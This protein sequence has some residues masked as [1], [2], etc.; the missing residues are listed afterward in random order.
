MTT[1]NA[2]VEFDREGDPESVR[3]HPMN[4]R[5]HPDAQKAAMN[6]SLDRVGWIG[7]VTAN[8]RTGH[9]LDGHER[10]EEAL[11]RGES[12]PII[13]VDIPEED[14]PFVLATFD[15]IAA[16][17]EYDGAVLAE[18]AELAD[19]ETPDLSAFLNDYI[20]LFVGPPDVNDYNDDDYDPT[21]T[22]GDS[23]S[24]PEVSWLRLEV[25]GDLLKRW[26]THRSG[27]TSDDAA[28]AAVLP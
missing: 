7:A 19:I 26:R 14:E 22:G 3:P 5:L 27:F 4:A 13:W 18:L 24:E 15:P 16:L 21:L 9:L 25:S 2:I 23:D 28:L 10:R 6:E 1:V 20:A 12:L 11:A 8:R 17:A